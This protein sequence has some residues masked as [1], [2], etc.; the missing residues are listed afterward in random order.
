MLC[1]IMLRYV[2]LRYVVILCY[3]MLCY[4]MLRY[5]VLYYVTLRYVTLCCVI[6]CELKNC[7]TLEG[8]I[9]CPGLRSESLQVLTSASSDNNST[10]GTVPICTPLM[11]QCSHFQEQIV[12]QHDGLAMGNPIL[13]PNCRN[14]PSAHRTLTINTPNTQTQ[15]YKLLQIPVRYASNI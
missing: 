14:L 12:I 15:N 4:I 7:Q 9:C 6:L 13:G 3:V 2:V 10:S 5:V 8:I 11:C 1:Y